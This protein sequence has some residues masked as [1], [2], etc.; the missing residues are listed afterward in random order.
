MSIVSCAMR[1]LL[2][3]RHVV[4][5]AHV[6]QPVGELDEQHPDVGGDGEQELAEVFGLRFLAA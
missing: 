1:L 3:G 6:V 4:E 5:R 2:F